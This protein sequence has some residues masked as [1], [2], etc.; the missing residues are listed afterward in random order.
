MDWSTISSNLWKFLQT[1]WIPVVEVGVG[2]ILGPNVKRLI[3]RLARKSPDKGILTF[4]SSAANVVIIGISILLAAEALGVKMNSVIA[5]LSALGLGVA[6]ALKENMANVAGGIQIL[7]TK[8]FEV[9][10]YVKVGQ[11]EGTV[12]GVE[13]MYTTIV[14]NCMEEIV[15]PNSNMVSNTIVNYS[16]FEDVEASVN[17]E[18][19]T[20]YNMQET[21]EK[22]QKIVEACT[23]IQKDKPVSIEV[24]G[25]QS[26]L[27]QFQ[28]Q[29]YVTMKNYQ[30]SLYEVAKALAFGLDLY[31][32]TTPVM[33]DVTLRKCE[34]DPGSNPQKVSPAYVLSA[35]GIH[36]QN[37]TVQPDLT[38]QRDPQPEPKTQEDSNDD[39]KKKDGFVNPFKAGEKVL[40]NLFHPEQQHSAL[41]ANALVEVMEDLDQ[42]PKKSNDPA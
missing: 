20:G 4:M 33:E 13:M 41:G 18:V 5:L 16:R 21:A 6:L 29:Y 38:A 12:I 23:L 1:A 35:N 34:E 37:K 28:A 24:T 9:G 22:A 42:N 19:P 14:T 31:S 25:I 40:E 11:Y 7:I 27:I 36:K 10:S 26:T 2:L 15:I 32:T 8:P 30:D 3:L 17:F 39:P